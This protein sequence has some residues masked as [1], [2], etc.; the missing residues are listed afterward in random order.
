M[1]R[2]EALPRR[3]RGV[4]KR[5]VSPSPSS[6]PQHK[7]ARR[8]I[9]SAALALSAVVGLFTASSIS[10]MSANAAVDHTLQVQ[11]AADEWLVALLDAETGARGYVIASRQDGM[12]EPYEAALKSERATAEH[13]K[14]LVNKEAPHAWNVQ[15]AEGEA[16]V[17]LDSLREL[18]ALVRAGRREEAMERVSSGVGSRNMEAFRASI[19]SLRQAEERIL[20]ERRAQ[21]RSRAGLALAGAALLSAAS[22]LVALMAWKIERTREELL[23]RQA[24][25]ARMRLRGLSEVAAA[26]SEVRTRAEVA[27]IVVEHGVRACGA[28]SC[29]LYAL[30]EDRS[31]LELLGER[32]VAPEIT[33]GIRRITRAQGDPATFASL[34]SGQTIWAENEADY[35]AVYPE[36]ARVKT[37][38]PAAKAF[39]SVPLIVEGGPVGLLAMGFFQPR[40]FSADERAFVETLC[41]QCAQALQRASRLEREDEVRTWFTT[42][43]L[44]IG[45]AVIATDAQGR[46]TFVNPVAEKLTGWTAAEARG[47]M[48]DEVFQV[49]C[50]ET[51]LP[52]QSPA[53]RVLR[54]GAVVGLANHTVLRSRS[55]VEIPID[56]SGAPIRGESGHL[57]GVVMVFRDVSKEKVD[58]VRREF[59]ARAGEVLGSSVDFEATLTAVARVAVPTI[60]DWCVVHLLEP[61]AAVPYQAAVAHVDPNKVRLVEAF[62]ERYPPDAGAAR[63]PSRV[64]KSGKSEL[65]P[66][67]P[68][69]LLEDSATDAEHLRRLNE[70]KLES[71]MVVPLR[72]GERTLGTLTFIY[73]DSS[74]RYTEGDLAFAEDFARRAALAIE[75]AMVIKD[76]Q[77]ARVR[78]RA[79][80]DE[81]EVASRAKDEFLAMVSHELRTPLTPILGWT[82]TLRGRSPAPEL[83]RGL[84]VIE[85]NARAQAKLIEDVLDVSRI[86]SG[87]LALALGATDVAE[88][89]NAAV[90][91]VTPAAEAKNIAILPDVAGT[92]LEIVADAD[93]VQQVV[94]NLLSNAVKF[95]PR[96][97]RVMLTARRDGAEVVISVCDTGEGIRPEV[98]PLIFEPFRQADASTTRRHGG[99][100]LGLAIVKHLVS[101]HG[102]SVR[103]D[104]EGLGQGATFTVRLPARTPV[105]ALGV[106]SP[107]SAM[108]AAA[109]L[110]ADAPRLDGLRVV[111]V[112]DEEDA[113]IVVGEALR[114]RGAEVHCLASPSEAVAEVVAVRPDVIVSD[115]GMPQM[116]GYSLIRK[117]RALPTDHG[118]RTPAV[119]L[120]AYAR[121]EDAQRAFAA[122]Y[123]MHLAKPVELA[124]LATVVAN[125]GGRSLAG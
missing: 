89:V 4:T 70:L 24:L 34:D 115:I 106:A 121:A 92:G 98:L 37:R 104:S 39:W 122:G 108:E 117:I 19:G 114:E 123:Q 40:T 83:D 14:Q 103:A 64:V 15:I 112:D 20:I 17:V 95:T 29:T 1:S 63:G 21:A 16:R 110:D 76:A 10:Y 88:V 55:G 53:A 65:Y 78:E 54:E 85:R 60:A 48:L 25:E 102:G 75:N 67:I 96:G 56:D 99:L 12:L 32:G 9:I 84:A 28:D 42:T 7:H 43:L 91:T 35:A 94:W 51:R 31:A 97:G 73:A 5:I 116:D 58:R 59:L 6:R 79:L 66:E 125:L 119:A 107:G 52:V 62:G 27:R 120:T 71:V 77:A 45:D 111:V 90:E 109:A 61:G 80:R 74:R 57:F 2:C 8:L 72:V 105:P 113:L 11:Q 18:V 68:A 30:D 33:D 50:E 118:G 49:F 3:Q 22:F 124:R 46:V 82:V 100:G 81:A 44:S 87:K 101:A 41:Q 26:L 36:L 38:G 13:V 69:A 93:R 86:V 47:R 23:R